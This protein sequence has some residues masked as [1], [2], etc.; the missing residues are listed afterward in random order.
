MIQI[1]KYKY[2]YLAISAILFLTSVTALLI[3]G[4][5]PGIDFTGGSLIELSFSDG[6]PDIADIQTTLEPMNLGTIIVQPTKENNLIVRT[7]YVSEA[8]HQQILQLVRA[9]FEGEASA[10]VTVET[11]SGEILQGAAFGA[12][13]SGSQVLEERVETIGPSISSHLR[14]RALSAGL[15]TVVITL[16]YIGYAFRR[17]S[18]PVAS[19]KYGLS[20]ILAMTYNII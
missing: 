3:F 20:A 1:M 16:F 13:T 12:K 4:F 2:V 18:R 17:V 15:A 7:R 19:W 14:G 5:K 10:P 9:R 6:R 11:T 8:E